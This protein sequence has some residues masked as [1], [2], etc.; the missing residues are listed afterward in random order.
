M[1][2]ARWRAVSARDPL[3]RRLSRLQTLS[4]SAVQF[5]LART[6][7]DKLKMLAHLPVGRWRS[8]L[9]RPW[10]PKRDFALALLHAE[11]L[12]RI[13]AHEA[14]AELLHAQA[15]AHP[16]RREV[17]ERWLDRAE[18]RVHALNEEITRSGGRVLASLAADLANVSD[19]P[20]GAAAE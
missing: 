16:H 4:L 3:E 15:R 14:I 17:L 20:H 18:L 8:A 19:V 13:L 12:T 10:D 9:V 2:H 1:G 6:A 11:R 5:L 7:T